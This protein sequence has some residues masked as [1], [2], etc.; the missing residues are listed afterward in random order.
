[1]GSRRVRA[2]R[3]GLAA[4]FAVAPAVAAGVA[5]L[6]LD[7]E[8]A[9]A[10]CTFYTGSMTGTYLSADM[11]NYQ[12]SGS[13]TSTGSACD[14]SKF[15]QTYTSNYGCYDGYYFNGSNFVTGDLGYKCHSAGNFSE[16]MLTDVVYLAQIQLT[17]LGGTYNTGIAGYK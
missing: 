1:M 16:V 7:S 8:P 10:A 5:T 12:I 9:G 14:N 3:A 6:A 2:A 17:N 15:Y 13:R 4:G 11:P